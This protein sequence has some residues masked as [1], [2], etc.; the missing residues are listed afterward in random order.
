MIWAVKHASVSAT[1]VDAGAAQ[2]FLETINEKQS[3]HSDGIDQS[4]M[5]RSKYTTIVSSTTNQ[6][7]EMGA[8]LGSDW[9]HIVDI[10]RL[11]DGRLSNL[12]QCHFFLVISATKSS[13]RLQC[14]AELHSFTVDHE[15]K[16]LAGCIDDIRSTI[17]KYL[18]S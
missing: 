10:E 6:C 16:W 2:F 5:K 17:G 14:R 3:K 18:S 1:F 11:C 8:A 15:R 9:S 7:E 12:I 13:H 4:V